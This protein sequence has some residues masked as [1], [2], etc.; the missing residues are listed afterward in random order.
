[1]NYGDLQPN[2]RLKPTVGLVTGLAAQQGP[3]RARPRL[4]WSV[5]SLWE[6]CSA[7]LG[8]DEYQSSR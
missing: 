2:N 1:M 4:N 7:I 6:Q 8:C 3:R 5:R